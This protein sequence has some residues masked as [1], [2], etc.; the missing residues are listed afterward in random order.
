MTTTNR[1]VQLVLPTGP[2]IN[3]K[4]AGSGYPVL[5]VHGFPLDATI[6]NET[7][8]AIASAGYQCIAPDLRGFGGSSL[9]QTKLTIGDL[10]EDLDQVRQA[11]IG[12]VPFVLVGLSLGG[13]VALEYWARHAKHLRGLVL[14]NTKPSTDTSEARQG[15]LDMGRK[16]LSDGT[17][18][19]VSPMLSKLISDASREQSPNEQ[20]TNEQNEQSPTLSDRLQQMM[21]AVPPTTIDFIQQ[22]MANRQSFVE[23]L[24]KIQLPTLVIAGEADKI[25]PPDENREWSARLPHSELHIIPGAAHL[26]MVEQPK[27]FAQKLH[28]FLERAFA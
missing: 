27:A 25:S 11:I 13:Y 24:S 10:A 19:A 14:T 4:I 26:P 2:T 12:D 28:D 9:I 1:T 22:A 6:W 16:A 3:V 18:N 20:S 8:D 15:R 7:M 21:S 23:R 5:F 17:W